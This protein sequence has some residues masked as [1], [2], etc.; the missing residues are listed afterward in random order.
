VFVLS[1]T[2]WDNIHK[3]EYASQAC[4]RNVAIIKQLNGII[5]L[6]TERLNH[7]VSLKDHALDWSDGSS[8][9]PKAC[10]VASSPGG[11]RTQVKARVAPFFLLDV[12]V[13]AILQP[14]HP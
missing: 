7:A 5:R 2:R 10:K 3:K 1:K 12:L 11:E 9:N 4:A 8:N 13:I 14:C 6:P